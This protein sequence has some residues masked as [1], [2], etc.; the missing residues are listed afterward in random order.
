MTSD[1]L[2]HIVVP[3]LLHAEEENVVDCIPTHLHSTPLPVVLLLV[4]ELHIPNLLKA[5]RT[6]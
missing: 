4:E 5:V 3:K 6:V 1:K 2:L